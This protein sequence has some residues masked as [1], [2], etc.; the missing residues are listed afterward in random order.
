[1]KTTESQGPRRGWILYDGECPFCRNLMERVRRT[2][3]SRGFAFAPLQ[4][5]WVA[6]R[7][8]LSPGQRPSEMRVF[9]AEGR[10]V[11]RADAVIFLAGFVCWA[12]PLRWFSR[13]PGAKRVFH[14]IYREIAARRSCDGGA[15]QLQRV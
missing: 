12:K 3:E 1:M 11:G 10:E 15:C 9:T 4:T 13:L 8:N 6:R 7:I 5:P 14:R 2:F